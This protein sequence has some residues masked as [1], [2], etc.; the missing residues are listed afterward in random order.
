MRL[1]TLAA[2][3]AAVVTPAIAEQAVFRKVLAGVTA[4]AIS[5]PVPNVGQRLHIITVMCPAASGA[6]SGLQVRLEASFDGSTWFPISGDVTAAPRL[7]SLTYQ[8]ERAFAP[9]PH[10]RVRV[11]Q[12]DPANPLDVWYSGH[13]KPV[14]SAITQELDRFLL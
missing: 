4:P 12:A 8:M 7:G 1:L 9:W 13:T 6:V 11:L 14:V 2:A 10:V 5:D 3:I